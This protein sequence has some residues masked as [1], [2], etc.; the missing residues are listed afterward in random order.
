M[1]DKDREKVSAIESILIEL[2][3]R[4]ENGPAWSSAVQAERIFEV[5]KSKKARKKLKKPWEHMAIELPG[6]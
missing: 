5:V 1:K 6:D 4:S 3:V 2:M